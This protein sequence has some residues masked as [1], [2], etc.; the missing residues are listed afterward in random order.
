VG[1]PNRERSV[2]L[3]T[4][5][6]VPGGTGMN[7][8]SVDAQPVAQRVTVTLTGLVSPQS[9]GDVGVNVS[10]SAGTLSGLPQVRVY[11]QI[12]AQFYGYARVVTLDLP[13]NTPATLTFRTEGTVAGYVQATAAT[14]ALFTGEF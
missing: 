2:G 11:A 10:T 1:H 7:T 12:G 3:N 4:G 5:T 14:K 9:A 13:A 6:Y 8:I